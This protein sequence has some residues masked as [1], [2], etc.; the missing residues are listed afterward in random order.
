MR[1]AR[2][3]LNLRPLP[4]QIPR[5][6]ASLYVGRLKSGKN[7]WKATGERRC[8]RPAAPTIRHG[9]PSVVLIPTAVSC[10]PSAAR[11]LTVTFGTTI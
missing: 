3:E 1:W 7:R 5:A 10:C 8:Q 2:E 4:C 9:S 11:R 6:F